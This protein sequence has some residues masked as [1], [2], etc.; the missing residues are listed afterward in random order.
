MGRTKHDPRRRPGIQS[1]L[2]A[3]CAETPAIAWPQSAEVKLRRHYRADGVAADVLATGV[4]AAIAK[5]ARHRLGRTDV[6]HAAQHVARRAT[7]GLAGR[8]VKRHRDLHDGKSLP[9]I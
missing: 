5:E 7:V 3:W 4:A 1:L 2:P 9:L 8:F 6:E